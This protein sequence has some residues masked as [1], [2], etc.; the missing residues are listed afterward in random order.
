MAV[1]W[2]MELHELIKSSEAVTEAGIFD[3]LFVSYHKVVK[4]F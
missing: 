1:V 4:C 3:S 2:D